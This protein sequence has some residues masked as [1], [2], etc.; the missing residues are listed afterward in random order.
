MKIKNSAKIAF[1]GAGSAFCPETMND[2]FLDDQLNEIEL[3]ICLMDISEK[4]LKLSEQY[5][6]EAAKLM[7]RNAK[8][9][10]T[11]SLEKAIDGADFVFTAIEV[12]RYYYWSMDFHIP[13]RYGS[14]QVYGENGGPGG[15]FHFLRNVGP[16]L[17]VAK[18]MECLAPD[19]W[20]I[21][22]SNPE[23]K[24]VEAISRLTNIKVVGLCHGIV[25]GQEFITS[26]L[27]IPEEDLDVEVCGM[28]HFGWYQKI[29]S[30]KTGEDLYPLLKKKELMANW[31][32]KWDGY[33]LSRILLRT[34]GL[35]AYPVTN[36]IG[37][38]I[39]WADN[40]IASPNMQFFHDPV[41]EDPWITKKISPLVYF[42]DDYK[43]VQFFPDSVELNPDSLEE[44][45]SI[46]AGGLK[47]SGEYGVSIIKAMLF[48]IKLD[49]LTVNMP[50][51]GKIP[52]LDD[53]MAVELPA[54][55]D[56]SGIHTMKMNFL[57]DAITEMIRTQGII[58]KLAT[59]AYVEKSRNKL[60]Q[61]LMLDPTVS[62]YQNVVAMINEMC[63]RQK[64]ILPAMYW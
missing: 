16:I 35:L 36:H 14:N 45:F 52:G 37:E 49:L 10:S 30:K 33:A 24:L 18:K 6:V 64:E 26:M 56:G 8:V 54:I 51:K 48:D 46:K 25:E 9:W 59:E 53:D 47:L 57:P 11:T 34:Y 44:R 58:T 2:I 7:K 63:E 60:L 42:A 40:F 31:Y 29:R 12:D 21:N 13:R 15:I 55:A 28:N 27:D 17:E 41:S 38:Y 1:I 39:R 23:A 32:A 5:A 3:E 4:P 62:N 61:A 19:A 50:N 20:L 43:D 22:Y